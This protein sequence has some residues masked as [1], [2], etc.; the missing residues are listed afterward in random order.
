M[1]LHLH[2]AEV[3]VGG[4]VE[5]SVE[6]VD[7]EVRYFTV[8]QTLDIVQQFLVCERNP[9]HARALLPSAKQRV[10]SSLNHMRFIQYA[11]LNC[12]SYSMQP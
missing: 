1:L 5:L 4:E 8:R 7:V 9:C 12:V 3:D 11:A 6:Q 2:V 10:V